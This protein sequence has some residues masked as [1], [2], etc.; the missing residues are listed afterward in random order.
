MKYRRGFVTN[1]SS[2]S[3]IMGFRSMDTII[4]ELY[5][6]T[7]MGGESKQEYLKVLLVDCIDRDNILSR[8]DV[9]S[10]YRSKAAYRVKRSLNFAIFDNAWP[11]RDWL[12]VKENAESYERLLQEWL[13]ADVAEFEALLEGKGYFVELEYSDHEGCLYSDLEHVVVPNLK[14]CLAKFNEH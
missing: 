10:R 8:E 5:N 13:D 4:S 11:D 6:D 12:G 9:V 1:S 2:S 3:F 7:A 14:C